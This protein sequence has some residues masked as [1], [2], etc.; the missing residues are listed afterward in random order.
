MKLHK[1]LEAFEELSRIVSQWRHIPVEAVKRDYLI[2]LLLKKLSESDF[3]NKVVFKGGTSLS[4]CYP[5]TIERFS[6]DIDLTFL[7]T[8]LSDKQKDK[9]IKQ[10]ETIMWSE[11]PFE[12]INDERSKSSKS[13][14]VWLEEI[15]QAYRIKLE[16]G[17]TI[18]PEPSKMMNLKTYIQEYLEESELFDLVNEYELTEISIRVLDIT[19]TFLD[20]VLAVKRHAYN[21]DLLRKVR[22]I[23]DVVKL[24]EN[25]EVQKFLHQPS[26]LKD[27]LNLT[28]STDGYY[29]NKRKNHK[30]DYRPDSAF[31]FEKWRSSFDTKEIK[32][33]YEGL[34]IDL[35]YTNERQKF[36][37]A[38]EV[39]EQIDRILKSVEM[40]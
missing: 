31:E 8:E 6:E 5:G 4:K 32:E 22:H 33:T 34:H 13:S 24:Y 39:F 35:L 7:G 3:V 36:D 27:L 25:T 9:V 12:K 23:Y 37:K 28:K 11:L 15:G 21:E 29:I 26:E 2:V 30:E 17:S 14:Y 16:I 18:R 20:K 1:D 38:V 19:R 40:T 10:I